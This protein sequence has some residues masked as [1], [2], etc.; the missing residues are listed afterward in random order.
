MPGPKFQISEMSES[1]NND[2]TIAIAVLNQRP[3]L[4]PNSIGCTQVEFIIICIAENI[5]YMYI[6][7]LY[8]LY[9]EILISFTQGKIN[10]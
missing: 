5:D 6:C 1:Q 8:I 2:N 9:V 10:Y 3:V 4:K 7:I